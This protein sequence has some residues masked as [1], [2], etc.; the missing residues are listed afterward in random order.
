M[1]SGASLSTGVVAVTPKIN[2]KAAANIISRIC[3][4]TLIL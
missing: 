1:I 4:L 2:G 3:M